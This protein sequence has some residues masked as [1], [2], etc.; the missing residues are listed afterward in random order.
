MCRKQRHLLWSPLLFTVF[1]LAFVFAGTVATSAQEQ[2]VIVYAD[3]MT[4]PTERSGE[5][6]VVY[7]L[8][9]LFM[10][11]HPH[12]KVELAWE[13]GN[14]DVQYLGGVSPDVVR[15]NQEALRRRARNNM[16]L[17]L[18][19]FLKRDGFDI[20]EVI[21]KFLLDEGF[22]E[23]GKLWGMPMFYGT[24]AV[25][26]N[27]NMF[28]RAGLGYPNTPDWS[29][30]VDFVEAGRKL[31]QDVDG[32]GI[33]DQFIATYHA[34]NLL[35]P[36][37]AARGAAFISD[38]LRTWLGNTNVTIEALQ[39][40]QDQ[41]H[42]RG[43]I[44]HPGNDRA[45]FVAQ[46]TAFQPFGS[47]G[48]PRMHIDNKFEWDLAE[49]PIS[50]VTG[51][52]GTRWNADGWAI[53]NQ[54]K[55][56][57]AAWEFVKFLASREAQEIIGR[58]QV[59][60]PPRIDVARELFINPMTPQDESVFIRAIEYMWVDKRHEISRD[61]RAYINTALDEIIDGKKPARQAMEEITSVVEA[62]LLEEFGPGGLGAGR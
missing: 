38:D 43:I 41:I 30:E 35:A 55:H 52:R 5:A 9:E 10:A 19:D 49:M 61:T 56:P 46:I 3:S 54:T 48:L 17:P 62:L 4:E 15:F 18:D 6:D 29:W 44:L 8:I 2:V 60:I 20:E 7:S 59:G 39:W 25:H 37:M 26:Y 24:L 47:W 31:L 42:S 45:N 1:A 21:P 28:D 58:G 14:F 53:S 34:S 50:T 36:F 51:R 33:P 27:V 13:S 16:L 57:E 40:M 22:R 11:K 23:Y 32:D 12:I